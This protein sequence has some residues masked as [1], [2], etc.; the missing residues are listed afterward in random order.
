[1]A[2]RQKKLK[3]L[4][5]KENPSEVQKFGHINEGCGRR[6]VKLP[7]ETIMENQQAAADLFTA[8]AGAGP[9]VSLGESVLALSPQHLGPK[10]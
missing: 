10:L 5:T 8:L 3:K 7:G 2:D 9:Y 4:P 6:L 1:M